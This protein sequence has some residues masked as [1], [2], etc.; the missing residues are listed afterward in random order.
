M[1]TWG[2][3]IG[4]GV[5]SLT[6]QVLKAQEAR[7]TLEPNPEDTSKVHRLIQ[8]GQE[9][10]IASSGGWLAALNYYGQA[11]RLAQVSNY[12]IGEANALRL[13]AQLESRTGSHEKEVIDHFLQELALREEI[14]DTLEIANTYE[15]IGKFFD[16]K[17]K[18]PDQAVGYY[19]Q[20]LTLKKKVIKDF[21]KLSDTYLNL[22][23]MFAELGE[24]S[25]AEEYFNPIL[26]DYQEK[27][28][29][30]NAAKISLAIAEMH[31][32][33]ENQAS[34]KGFLL[35]AKSLY[36]KARRYDFQDYSQ[37]MEEIETLL[38]PFKEHKKVN[39]S[40]WIGIIAALLT[41]ILIS[42]FIFRKYLKKQV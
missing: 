28:D 6:F 3:I 41:V 2:V 13:I 27:E 33:G 4:L 38:A 17:L 35:K 9:A 39:W 42:F 37:E 30:A 5:V 18:M 10:E 21:D 29:F 23:H 34:A 40:L 7:L 22:A 26:N 15:L 8:S 19:Q 1:N 16:R 32:Q 31:L 14:G 11:Y 20:A 12:T 24:F 25:K 36:E